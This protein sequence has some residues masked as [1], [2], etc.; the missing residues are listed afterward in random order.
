MFKLVEAKPL[1]MSHYSVWLLDGKTCCLFSTQLSSEA[2]KQLN[3][4]KAR[5]TKDRK[6]DADLGLPT[7][8]K[9]NSARKK[10]PLRLLR[11]FAGP[12]LGGLPD[13]KIG[14]LEPKP[15]MGVSKS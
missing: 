9:D 14:P 2:A 3:A 8:T 10:R 1:S 4:S 7:E 12:G 11:A 5:T 6:N 13:R 15:S